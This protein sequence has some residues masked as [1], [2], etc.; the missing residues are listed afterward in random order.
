MFFAV[1]TTVALSLRVIVDVIPYVACI[2]QCLQPHC[3]SQRFARPHKHPSPFT[4]SGS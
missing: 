3:L 4:A 2:G 1:A